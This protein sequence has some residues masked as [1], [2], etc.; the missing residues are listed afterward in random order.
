[1]RENN[2]SWMPWRE[3]FVKSYYFKH[4]LVYLKDIWSSIKNSYERIHKGYS[5]YDI[6]NLDNYLITVIINSLKDYKENNIGIPD[7]TTIEEYNDKLDY[8]IHLFEE[9][10]KDTEKFPRMY[11]FDESKGKD[12]IMKWME[13]EDKINE[14]KDKCLKEAFEKF[15]EIFHTLWI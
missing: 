2:S 5:S 6:G 12:Y 13:E 14:Y 1:M 3:S 10:E 8:I 9:S 11:P 4:P 7:G 15:Y